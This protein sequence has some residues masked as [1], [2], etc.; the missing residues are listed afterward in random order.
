M[1]TNV[2]V[3]YRRDDAAAEA[4]SIVQFV[5]ECVGEDSVFLDTSSISPGESWP[6]KLKNKIEG[7]KTVI[8]VI[9]PEWVR[10]ADQWGRRRLDDPEDWVRKEIETALSSNT[11]FYR[12]W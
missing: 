11:N 6:D 10:I 12:Y 4:S 1:T 7:A 8:A 5:K 9:G 2:F 3:S